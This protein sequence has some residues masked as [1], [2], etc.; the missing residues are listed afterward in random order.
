MT[1]YKE[2]LIQRA[3]SSNPLTYKNINYSSTTSYGTQAFITGCDENHEWMIP[4]FLDNYRKYN[5]LPILFSNFGNVSQSLIDLFDGEVPITINNNNT[6]NWFL[7]PQV[8]LNSPVQETCWIDTDCEVRDNIED[9]FSYIEDN[10]LAMV[11]DLPWSVRRE[12]KWHNSGVVAIRN[13]PK[14]LSDWA[15]ACI[16]NP[17]QGD[18]EVLYLLMNNDLDTRVYITD[19]PNSYNVLRLQ[20]IDKTCPPVIK[21]LHHTGTKGKDDIRKQIARSTA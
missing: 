8:L 11:E 1:S 20:V 13:K 3:A 14:I 19:V 9:I 4:W 12:S 10:R 21:I 15:R 17:V 18:Q 5:N 2:A 6:L 7:K 16:L